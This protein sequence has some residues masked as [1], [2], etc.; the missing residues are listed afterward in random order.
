MITFPKDSRT[1]QLPKIK[2][3]EMSSSSQ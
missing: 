2:A 3:S 1:K